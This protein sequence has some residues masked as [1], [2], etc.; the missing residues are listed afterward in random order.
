MRILKTTQTY[1]PYLHLGG[2][3]AKVRGIARELVRR[4]HEVTVLTAYLGEADSAVN[5]GSWEKQKGDWG[6]ESRHDAVEAIYLPTVANYRAT[7][8]N[9][10]VLNFC[11]RRLADYDV[12]HIF[13][14]Y[15]TVGS[16][17]AWC[18]RRRG[19]PYVLEPL[20]MFGP[21]VRSQQKKR[22]YQRLVGN[23][24]FKGAAMVI[25]TS[26]HE[27]QELITG[28]IAEE[29]V[30]LRRNGLDLDEFHSL[31]A[32]GALRAKLCLA[33]N[34]RLVLFLGRLSFIKGL[35]VLVRAF[36]DVAATRGDVRLVI[37]GPDD[38][39]GCREE[40]LRL[41]EKLKVE[42]RVSFPGPLYGDQKLQA[43]ADADLFVLSSQYESFG[44]AAAEAIACGVPVLVTKG[45]G[46]AP[47]IDQRAGLVVECTQE[48][49]QA[50]L[51]RLLG[52]DALLEAF[53]LGCAS[54]AQGL[55]WAEPVEQMERIYS[56]LI[57]TRNLSRTVRA[58]QSQTS[59]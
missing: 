23:A 54:V 36:A 51:R 3:P 39:D 28:G 15:D 44:N 16:V 30:V 41:V 2:P 37:A 58:A 33:D 48:G 56:S 5:L 19:V 6:W 25:A 57:A 42:H 17:T 1:Y 53:G 31:P 9:P 52:D 43:L 59:S 14:L 10:R 45:C 29:K 55:S 35:D 32:R 27:R 12:V 47:L 34:E 26:E 46:I 4:G 7:T 24:L 11:A 49:L 20:G 18:C 40:V 8:M 50:G 13:G 21:K 22:V 38:E